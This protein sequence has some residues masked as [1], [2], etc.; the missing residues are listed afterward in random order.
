MASNF[1]WYG[2]N[3]KQDIVFPT[4]QGVAVYANE[5]NDIVIRQ[6]GV[7]GEDDTIVIVPRAQVDALISAIK[8]ASLLS[9]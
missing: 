6:Q 9:E 2:D 3:D 4:T 1:D 7:M 8:E 5:S